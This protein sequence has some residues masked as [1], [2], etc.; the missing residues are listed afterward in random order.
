MTDI[1]AL[2]DVVRQTSLAIHTFGA[3][4]CIMGY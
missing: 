4:G 1:L 2:C 3:H